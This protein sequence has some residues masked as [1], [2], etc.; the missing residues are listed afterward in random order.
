MLVTCTWR[1]ALNQR[2]S[3]RQVQ[4]P[5]SPDLNPIEPSFSKLKTH[6]RKAGERSVPA[7]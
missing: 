5:Y 6:L 7:L 4:P 2:V 1:P 3:F